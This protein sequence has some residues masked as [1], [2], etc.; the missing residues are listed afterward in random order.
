MIFSNPYHMLL[1]CNE[2]AIYIYIYINLLGLIM[3]K[4]FLKI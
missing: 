3:S 1:G 4:L 2:G